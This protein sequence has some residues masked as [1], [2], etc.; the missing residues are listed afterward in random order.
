MLADCLPWLVKSAIPSRGHFDV[1]DGVRVTALHASPC[2]ATAEISSRCTY[3]CPMLPVLS[4]RQQIRVKAVGLLRLSCGV[5]VQ[6]PRL[7]RGFRAMPRP[8][9]VTLY[10][11]CHNCRSGSTRSY[12]DTQLGGSTE[13]GTDRHTARPSRFAR[14][15]CVPDRAV[16]YSP[17]ANTLSARP[18]RPED[19][20]VG[21]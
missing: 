20:W 4:V 16:M 6:P 21:I 15:P 5:V 17:A 14:Q 12:R 13:P 19:M 3:P 18:A 9:R 1:V 7:P 10:L 8:A 11:E 2:V